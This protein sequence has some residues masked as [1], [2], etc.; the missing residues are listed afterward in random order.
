MTLPEV[1]ETPISGKEKF[2]IAE[3]PSVPEFN[4]K[5]EKVEV[6]IKEDA[7]LSEPIVGED[8]AVILDNPTPQQGII[9]KLP[10]TDDQMN[11]ALRLKVIY[12]LRWLAEWT[13]R[14]LKI[15]GGKFIY[16]Y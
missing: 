13:K 10:L 15:L 6:V 1:R 3:R 14:A 4:P 8:G 2:P 9:I 16:R 12:S 11:Q 7:V 5:I